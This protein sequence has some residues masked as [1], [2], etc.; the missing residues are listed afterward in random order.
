MAQINDTVTNRNSTGTIPAAGF[1]IV[2]ASG[3]PLNFTASLNSVDA[4]RKIEFSNDGVN[5]EP[6]TYDLSSVNNLMLFFKA[7][8]ESV[9][10]TG[11]VGNRW[12]I[13]TG[14][15]G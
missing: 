10:F 3:L 14:D 13:T 4:G 9:K 1:F 2:P 11:A 8:C 15:E 7:K 12:G 5:Y 6:W